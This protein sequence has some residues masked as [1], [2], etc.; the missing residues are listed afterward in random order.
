MTARRP[1][2][3]VGCDG[4]EHSQRA[5]TWAAS[6]AGLADGSLL[7]LSAWQWPTFQ[8]VPI[9]PGQWRPDR[10]CVSLVHRL[11]ATVPLP[12]DRVSTEV[13]HGRAAE[14][15]SSRSR[16][17]D[18]LVV[19]AHGL[20]ALSRLTLGS[21][22]TYC[23]THASCPVAIVREHEA[24][25]DIG[26]LVGVDES[27]TAR[28]ALRWAMDYADLTDQQLTVIHAN[29]APMPPIRSDYPIFMSYPREI[30]HE[31]LKHWLG[32]LV[33]KEQADRGREVTR[34]VR[35]GVIDGN[36]D[37]VMVEQSR[38]ATLTVCGRGSPG[39]RHVLL[40]SVAS[41]LAHNGPGTLVVVPPAG[42]E[43]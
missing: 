18:L 5:V 29:E 34:G 31:E 26:V 3:L 4:S 43:P 16:D 21:V 9:T 24:V 2:V 39:L 40:G 11:R 10:D 25:D 12:D 27:E 42:D 38:R 19:G 8:D 22:S 30:T 32:N 6:Y 36:P 17:A 20:G 7:F 15:L 37:Q 33:D 13:T 1:I 28:T 23:T 14:V 35:L 41:A